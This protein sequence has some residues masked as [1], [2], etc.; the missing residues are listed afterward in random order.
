MLSAI[1]SYLYSLP[2]NIFTVAFATLLYGITIYLTSFPDR[3]ATDFYPIYVGIKALFSGVSPYGQETSDFL[4]NNW[5]VVTSGIKV[6]PI[7]AYPIPT[8][9]F[10]SPFGLFPDSIAPLLWFSTI[11]FAIG[12]SLYK[13]SHGN[14]DIISILLFFPLYH[15]ITIKNSSALWLPVLFLCLFRIKERNPYL[16]GLLLAFL[17]LKPQMGLLF[18]P[19]ALFLAYKENRSAIKWMLIF[20]SVL[21]ITSFIIYPLWIIDWLEV[22]KTYRNQLDA[23]ISVLL[24]ILFL[25]AAILLFLISIKNKTKPSPQA[26]ISILTLALFPINNIYSTMLLLLYYRTIG[27]KPAIILSLLSMTAFLLPNP[28]TALAVIITVWLPLIIFIMLQVK[29]EKQ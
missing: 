5:E 13:T 8:L 19:Y 7:S 9:L 17:P 28:N 22:V 16:L 18:F 3:Q 1:K 21:W 24:S 6:P 2:Y 15:A 23:N 12:F 27:Q 14:G 10:L 26:F 25:F 11:I 20:S 4:K 29:K